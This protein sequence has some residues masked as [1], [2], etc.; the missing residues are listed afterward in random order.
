MGGLPAVNQAFKKN[1]VSLSLSRKFLAPNDF[2]NEYT[3]RESH[4]WSQDGQRRVAAEPAA[5]VIVGK[6]QGLPLVPFTGYYVSDQSPVNYS[7]STQNKLLRIVTDLNN[8]HK[9]SRFFKVQS[10]NKTRR[11]LDSSFLPQSLKV[12]GVMPL[13]KWVKFLVYLWLSLAGQ[14]HLILIINTVMNVFNLWN[15]NMLMVLTSQGL[16]E[17]MNMPGLV[18]GRA[19]LV[20]RNFTLL[21]NVRL[22]LLNHVQQ[23]SIVRLLDKVGSHRAKGCNISRWHSVNVS[24]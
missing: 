4:V 13:S 5:Q 6:L 14:G 20:S 8:T 9:V 11:T 12:I 16:N 7:A 17:T 22:F 24:G 2:P 3:D 15:P 1:A 18:H 10:R 23:L 19:L 21:V